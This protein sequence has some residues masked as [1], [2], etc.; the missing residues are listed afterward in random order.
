[1]RQPPV[2]WCV[3]GVLFCWSAVIV[4]LIFVHKDLIDLCDLLPSSFK[5]GNFFSKSRTTVQLFACEC[6]VA[7]LKNKFFVSPS[8]FHP[9]LK[10]IHSSSAAVAATTTAQHYSC[11]FIQTFL[12]DFSFIISAIYLYA[13]KR[14][15]NLLYLPFDQSRARTHIAIPLATTHL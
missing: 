14:L 2:V 1:M 15:K 6:V 12:G 9:L 5:K 13:W 8:L 4:P 3:S 11:G 10:S 7:M